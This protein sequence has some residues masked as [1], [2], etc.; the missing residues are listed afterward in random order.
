MTERPD[1]RRTATN[2][3]KAAKNRNEAHSCGCSRPARTGYVLC[4]HCRA[5]LEQHLAEVP[6]L[7]NELETSLTRAKG[8]DY[9]TMGSAHGTETP[10]PMNTKA[11][12]LRDALKAEMVGWVRILRLADETWPADRIIAIDAWL[13][14]RLERI[15]KH[16]EAWAIYEGITHASQDARALVFAKAAEKRLVGV[17]EGRIRDDG[18]E[19]TEEACDGHLYAAEQSS[20]AECIKCRRSYDADV[21]RAEMLDQL[22][23]RL[24]NKR[25][26]ARLMGYLSLPVNM[27]VLRSQMYRWMTA[28]KDK[29]AKIQPRIHDADGIP[30]YNF[31]EVRDALEHH[32]RDKAV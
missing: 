31:G 18:D 28:T 26:I 6:W 1:T 27:D 5:E 29:P 23:D 12:D 13:M 7:L 8:I 10:L 22:N 14:V 24:A 15:A 3:S 32:Y 9:R 2:G 11:S 30:L 4:D 19:I 16:D 25:Q 20:L 21:K 17:C